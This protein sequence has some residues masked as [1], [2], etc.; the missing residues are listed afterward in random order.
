MRRSGIAAEKRMMTKV[1]SRK[2]EWPISTSWIMIKSQSPL[3][4]PDTFEEV[5]RYLTVNNKLPTYPTDHPTKATNPD[6]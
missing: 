3:Q 1:E 6:H 5:R 4:S 2:N